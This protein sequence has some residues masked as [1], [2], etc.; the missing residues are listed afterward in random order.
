MKFYKVKDAECDFCKNIKPI[1]T[2]V[3]N[4]YICSECAKLILKHCVK[5]ENGKE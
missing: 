1:V 2:E 5:N 3:E 4:I